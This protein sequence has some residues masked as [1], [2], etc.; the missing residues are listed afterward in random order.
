[1]P[2]RVHVGTRPAMQLAIAGTFEEIQR[3]IAYHELILAL[4]ERWFTQRISYAQYMRTHRRLHARMQ[5]YGIP[6]L[7]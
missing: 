5:R 6:L 1:M 4:G 2:D 7:R 3:A